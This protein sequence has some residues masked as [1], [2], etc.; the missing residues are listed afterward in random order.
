MSWKVA[1][2]RFVLKLP[3]DPP[4]HCHLRVAQC[5]T[6]ECTVG[7]F[8]CSCDRIDRY[9]RHEPLSCKISSNFPYSASPIPPPVPTKAATPPPTMRLSTPPRCG[10]VLH[11]RD[12]DTQ[13]TRN[14][15]KTR[16]SSTWKS[17]RPR[18]Q[19]RP[20]PPA[21]LPRPP[22]APTTSGSQSRPLDAMDRSYQ[23]GTT[24]RAH[25]ASPSGYER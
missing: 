11:R 21:N 25:Q 20:S 2:D 13:R 4:T 7:Q 9:H 16:I 23:G 5:S 8:Q 18:I 3:I 17:Y 14:F 1:N 6:L 15:H 10:H 24:P 19:S 12:P 22:R